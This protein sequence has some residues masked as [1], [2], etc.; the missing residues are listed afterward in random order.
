MSYLEF[1]DTVSKFLSSRLH[2]QLVGVFFGFF[3]VVGAA[4]FAFI[5]WL[6][7]ND[8]EMGSILLDPTT[9]GTWIFVSSLLLLG[10]ALIA[11]SML[12]V[13]L[14]RYWTCRVDHRPFIVG[15]YMLMPLFPV[16]TIFSIFALW[17]LN[18]ESE[19][20][21]TTPDGDNPPE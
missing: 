4:F 5:G 3:F 20:I 15:A 13:A 17:T 8:P 10:Y 18:K 19:L 14:R 21:V 1:W 7:V 6:A 16:G 2:A 12:L 11:F 9:I